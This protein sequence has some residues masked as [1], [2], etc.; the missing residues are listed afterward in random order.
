VIEVERISWSGHVY[1][2][3]SSE[4]WF[5]ANG[6]I[7]SNCDCIHRPAHASSLKAARDEGL[8]QDPY[9]YFKTLS[10]AE[11]DRIFTTSGAQA[12]R[13]GADMG[14]VVNARRGMTE[15]GMFTNEGVGKRGFARKTLKPNQRRLTPE[16]IY[17]LNPNR[18]DVIAELERHGYLLPGGQN[19][20]GAIKGTTHEGFGELG[21]GGTRKAASEAV[22][23][24]RE[25]GVRAGD[26][27][28]M[29]A[30]ERRL[31]DAERDWQMVLKGQNP[32]ASPGFGNTPDPHG[33]R[34]N[35]RGAGG[36]PLTPQIAA[37]VEAN[38]RRQLASLGQIFT[39]TR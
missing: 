6:L 39:R 5:S 2:L 35:R 11:Q 28:T 25:T 14:R 18:A 38:Y 31:A 1:N 23:T 16:A 37:T 36:S 10:P 26:R 21:R 19:P 30:A 15:N 8:V 7:V 12:V 34:L 4:G 29:T 22:V 27:Y 17:K 24:A 32:Y 9:E 13:D 20:L 3:T 33:L